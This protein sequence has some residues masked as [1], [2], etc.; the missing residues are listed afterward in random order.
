MGALV[1]RIFKMEF[2]QLLERNSETCLFPLD[3]GV[4]ISP[5]EEMW[6]PE[7]LHQY[8][9]DMNNRKQIYAHIYQH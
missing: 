6:P 2:S 1:I 5:S 8:C 9:I 4:T 3:R 7:W